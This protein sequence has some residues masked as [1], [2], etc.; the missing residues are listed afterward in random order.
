M[1]AM[2][3]WDGKGTDVRCSGWAEE[4][5]E[6]AATRVEEG[7]RANFKVSRFTRN[8]HVGCSSAPRLVAWGSCTYL[9]TLLYCTLGEDVFAVVALRYS[10]RLAFPEPVMLLDSAKIYLIVDVSHVCCTCVETHGN[11]HLVLA[12]KS[13]RRRTSTSTM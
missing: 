7:R 11:G 9:A 13:A 4:K 5:E 3:M 6:E 8:H 1:K 2:K 12:E 10:R